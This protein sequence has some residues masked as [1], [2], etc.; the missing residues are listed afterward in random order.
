MG[1][2][3]VLL[4]DLDPLTGTLSFLLKIKSIY[5][6]LDALQRAHELDAD[7]WRR[8]GHHR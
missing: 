7:L 4:A 6:F 1:A 5:S 8:H 2:N 3:Q